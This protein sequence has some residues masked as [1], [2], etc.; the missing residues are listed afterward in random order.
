MKTEESMVARDCVLD[1]SEVMT[2]LRGYSAP[3]PSTN[4]SVSR[5][6]GWVVVVVEVV[7]PMVSRT[8][9]HYKTP[10]SK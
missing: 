9:A 8:Y 5:L 2:A 7:Q 1:H 3:I 4:G 6:E 10:P